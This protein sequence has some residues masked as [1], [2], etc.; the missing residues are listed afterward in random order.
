MVK[1]CGLTEPDRLEEAIALGAAFVG[2]IFYPPSQRCLRPDLARNLASLVPPSVA[3]VGVV[4]DATDDELAT[5][6]ADVP[7]DILQLH[8]HETPARASE[9]GLQTG[10]RIMKAIRVEAADDLRAVPDFTEVAD[11]LLFDA[12]PP[13]TE[14]VIPGGNGLP[15]DW[16]LLAERS[17]A[18]PW[19]LAGG[20]DPDNLETAVRLLRPP[21]VD[22]S[23]G[24][25]IRPGVKDRAKLERFLSTAARLADEAIAAEQTPG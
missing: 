6:L 8:G 1:V 23:S 18:L 14:G 12:K 3:T 15:F 20:L 5:I 19:A 24:I 10:C 7:L 21:M 17:F 2:F 13:R 9:I 16:R 4:V 22:V 25:E 11:L